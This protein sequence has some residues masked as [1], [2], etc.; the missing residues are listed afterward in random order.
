[1]IITFALPNGIRIIHK[2]TSSPV[3]FCGLTINTG[4][5]DEQESEHGMAHFL[6]HTLFKGTSKR[7]A[8]HINNRLDNVGGEFNAF[9]TKEETVVQACVTSADFARAVELIADVTFNSIF[10]EHEI[11]KEK[12]VICEEIDSYCD[13]PSDLIF[14][15][16]ED[17]LFDG[18]PIGRNILGTKKIINSF[19]SDDIIKFVQRTYN[20]DQMVFSSTG[21]ISESR[22]KYCCEKYFGEQMPNM[23]TF[24]RVKPEKYT[25]F[26]RSVSKKTHQRH[27]ILGNRAY[28]YN[29]KR[30]V[31]LSLLLNYLGGPATNSVLNMLLREKHGLVYTVEAGYT[32]YN[33]TGNVTLYFA[34]S[35]TNAEHSCDLIMKELSRIKTDFLSVYQLAKAKK[36]FIG[37]YMIAQENSEQVMQTMGKSM[38][39]HN[40]FEDVKMFARQIETV[41]APDIRN[42]ANEI[43]GLD[44]ISRLEYL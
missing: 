44:M 40:C 17:L 39:S 38:L 29:D 8:Y 25:V 19:S 15:D 6:E 34:A 20:T 43:F 10:P 7:K 14:D 36:Q 18:Y 24:G 13:S 1:M 33:D 32:P 16:F 12:K 26:N 27:V 35:E 11:T 28:A 3:V 5:R 41:T 4:T 37:Q 2:Y 30:R 31:A 22:L 42:V 23:R 9:T 21:K